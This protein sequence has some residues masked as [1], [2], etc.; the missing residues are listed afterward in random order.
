MAGPCTFSHYALA[1]TSFSTLE[2]VFIR[3]GTPFASPYLKFLCKRAC[4]D[5]CIA[6]RSFYNIN[7]LSTEKGTHKQNYARHEGVHV[8][9]GLK[10]SL[11]FR[12]SLPKADLVVHETA[13]YVFFLNRC[14]NLFAELNCG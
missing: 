6:S 10:I 4:R 11:I 5:I 3:H 7:A 13:L 12:S 9:K 2:G 14:V 1:L 8:D